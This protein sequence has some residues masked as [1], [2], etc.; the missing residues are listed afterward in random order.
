MGCA[1]SHDAFTAVAAAFASRSRPRRA[2]PAALCRERVA[3]IRAADDRRF[4]L[5]AAHAAYFRSLAAVGDALRRFAAAGLLP[6]TPPP[7]SSPVLTLPPSPAKPVASSAA[8]ATSSLP[9]SPSSSSTVSPLS[10][11]LS[12]ENLE[13]HADAKQAGG[14][15]SGKAG[16]SKAAPSPRHHYMRNN[17]TVPTVVYEHPNAQYTEG[18]TSYGYGYGYTYSYGPYGEVVAEERPETAPR[19]PGPP[20]SPPTAEISPW[21]FFDPFTPYDQFLEDYSRDKGQV[22]ANLTTN[23][24]NY[25]ELRRMEGIPE[26]ED[27][28]ELVAEAEAS[29]PSTSG[30]ADQNVKG[31]RP[32]PTNAGSKGESADGKLQRKGSGANGEA[33]K[34]VPRNASVPSNASSKSKKGGKSNAASLKGTAGGDIDGGSSTGK[35]KGVSFDEDGGGHGKSMQ[36]ALSSESFSPLHHGNGDV[37]E[38]IHEVKERFDEAL[39]CGAEVSRLL[40]VGKLPHR[41]TPRVLRCGFLL[42]SGGSYSPYCAVLFLPPKAT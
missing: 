2:D 34:P 37:M 26:L 21:E 7:G 17:S 29:K 18:E 25:A 19:P 33:E 5:A 4:A 16:P 42:Q 15:G 6:A 23:S 3:L 28:A 13:A 8:A 14:R 39:N 12:D 1:S 41:T 9:P 31:K 35:N 36:S 32:V 11:S 22:D 30:V 38:A 27:E 20:P 40:E 10:H 24:P